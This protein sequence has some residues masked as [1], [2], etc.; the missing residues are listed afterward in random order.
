MFL[1]TEGVLSITSM[2]IFFHDLYSINKHTPNVPILSM[3]N[4]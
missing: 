3:D 2:L 1:W 4:W